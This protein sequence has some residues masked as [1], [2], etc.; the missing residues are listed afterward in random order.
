MKYII[1][2][3]DFKLSEKLNKLF[4]HTTEHEHTHPEIGDYILIDYLPENYSTQEAVKCFKDIVN[5]NIATIIN[6]SI[7]KIELLYDFDYD[8][9][10]KSQNL[11]FTKLHNKKCTTLL[12]LDYVNIIGT[13]KNKEELLIKIRANKYNL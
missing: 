11:Y 2:I 9:L 7:S 3:K 12:S 6:L 4:E 10:P 1:K 5:N 8:S 13:S